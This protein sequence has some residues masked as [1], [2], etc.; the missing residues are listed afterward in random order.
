LQDSGTDSDLFGVSFTDA[1]TGWAVGFGGTILHTDDGGLTWTP[2]DSGTTDNLHGVV[3]LPAVAVPEAPAV[4]E[5]S[6]LMLLGAG[7]AA[8]AARRGRWGGRGAARSAPVGPHK[9][10]VAAS[11]AGVRGEKTP[12]AFL[13]PLR[14]RRANRG[15]P[16]RGRV[17]PCGRAIR[18]G[19]A[20]VRNE[21]PVD[22]RF[23]S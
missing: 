8:L 7:I 1:S 6:S 3:F 14:E 21:V 19:P 2:Q 17:R 9:R 16:R 5:P 15:P 22:H 20:W 23:S 13:A 11:G 10:P 18:R 4:P 12:G